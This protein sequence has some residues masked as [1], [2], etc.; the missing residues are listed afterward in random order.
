[1]ERVC[2]FPIKS[3]FCST[4]NLVRENS[5]LKQLQTLSEPN[6]YFFFVEAKSQILSFLMF[7]I[8]FQKVL[9]STRYYLMSTNIQLFHDG[10]RYLIETSPLICRANQWTGFYVT[11]SVMKEL[12]HDTTLLA[13]QEC[14]RYYLINKDIFHIL[15][16]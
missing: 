15:R 4:H 3:V 11:A 10:G 9:E 1:M 7:L 14:A 13:I 6:K 12:N 5:F 8:K 16:S 2:N